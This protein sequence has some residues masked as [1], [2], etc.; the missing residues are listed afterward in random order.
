MY[1][2]SAWHYVQILYN[3]LFFKQSLS[4][5]SLDDRKLNYLRDI[6]SIATE[7]ILI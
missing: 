2:Q 3:L 1:N 6:N 7:V 4:I 5:S